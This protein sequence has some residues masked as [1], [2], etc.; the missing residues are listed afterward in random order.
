MYL[1]STFHVLPL[2]LYSEFQDLVSPRI[3][4][5]PNT[6]HNE[7]LQHDRCEKPKSSMATCY[8]MTKITTLGHLI[9]I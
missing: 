2:I 1:N 9:T 7:D 3:P 8:H 4:S 5:N 6:K